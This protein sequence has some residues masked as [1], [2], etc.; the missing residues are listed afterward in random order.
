[1]RIHR[2]HW[3]YLIILDD[4]ALTVGR[5]LFIVEGLLCDVN[6]LIVGP[7]QGLRPVIF[8]VFDVFY[9]HNIIIYNGKL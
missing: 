5:M 9:L 4:H 7:A 3:S 2:R 1:M 8:N 6:Y